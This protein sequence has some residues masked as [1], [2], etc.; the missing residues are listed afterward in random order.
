[1]DDIVL[2]PLAIRWLLDRLPAHIANEIGRTR[3]A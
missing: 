2:V 3:A 1:M